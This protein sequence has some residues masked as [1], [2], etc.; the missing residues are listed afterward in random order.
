MEKE[1]E[2][3]VHWKKKKIADTT[4]KQ[5]RDVESIDIEKELSVFD[6]DCCYYQI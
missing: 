5:R 1:E 3:L 4:S 6:N 2:K